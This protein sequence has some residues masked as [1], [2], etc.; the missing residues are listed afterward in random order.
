MRMMRCLSVGSGRGDFPVTVAVNKVGYP[1]GVQSFVLTSDGAFLVQ[2]SDRAAQTLEFPTK[3]RLDLVPSP[4][5]E[6]ARQW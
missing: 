3:F 5:P 1:G 2:I 6:E 4:A